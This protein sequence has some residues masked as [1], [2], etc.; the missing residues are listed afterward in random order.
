MYKSRDIPGDWP[1]LDAYMGARA[2]RPL[3]HNT[4][5]YRIADGV[6]GIIYHSTK[7]AEVCQDGSLVLN[8][9]GYHTVT[10]KARLNAMLAGRGRVYSERYDW[11]YAPGFDFGHPVPFRDHMIIGADGAVA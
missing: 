9:G 4:V 11:K 8:T 10:T 1:T 7:I 2:T 5:A 3:A 6:I